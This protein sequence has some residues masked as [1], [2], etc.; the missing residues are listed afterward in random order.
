MTYPKLQLSLP[1]LASARLR[2][3]EASNRRSPST[4]YADR[5]GQRRW[6]LSSVLPTKTTTAD[7]SAASS[8]YALNSEV[9]GG[10]LSIQGSVFVPFSLIG[11]K[12]TYL[13][14]EL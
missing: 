9:P 12:F 5:P 3:Q 7:G 13:K 14:K 10:V 11:K 2:C 4:F 8:R 6:Y 1:Q